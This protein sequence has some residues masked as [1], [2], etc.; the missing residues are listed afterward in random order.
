MNKNY[1]AFAL[2]AMLF[3]GSS[4]RPRQRAHHVVYD[5]THFQETLQMPEPPP[6]V[7][8]PELT[9]HQPRVEVSVRDLFEGYVANHEPWWWDEPVAPAPSPVPAPSPFAPSPVAPPVP[10]QDFA[11]FFPAPAV[12]HAPPATHTPALGL[13]NVVVASLISRHSA[14]TL[15]S[16]LQHDGHTVLIAPNEWGMF[17]VIVGTFNDRSSA[18][19]QRER[20]SR[21]YAAK[22]SREVLRRRYGVPFDDLWILRR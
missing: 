8:A 16:R 1:V 15:Q 11:S 13:Y 21:L 6:P 20:I 5:T 17:R 2:L 7:A 10:A 4:C 22:G 14:E 19:A 18:V 12:A 9:A 3:L